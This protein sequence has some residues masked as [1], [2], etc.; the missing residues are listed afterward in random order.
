[1]NFNGLDSGLGEYTSPLHPGLSASLD[2]SIDHSLD[3]RLDPT[4]L[5]NMELDGDGVQLDGMSVSV[6]ESVHLVEGMYSELHTVVAEVGVPVTASHFDLQD[7]LLWVGNHAGHATSFFGPT[8]E[9]YSSFRVNATDDVR[10]IQSIESGVLFLNKNNLK[11]FTR[12]GLV[13]FD[14]VMDEID[15]MHSLLLTDNDSVLLGGLQNHIREIDLNAVQESEK[16]TVEVPGV[17]IMRQSNRFFFC[18]HTSGKVSLRDLRSFKLEHEFDAY[19]GSLSDFDVHGN[20]LVTCGFSN[21]MNGLS[22][23]RFLM[24][25][26]LRMMRAISPLQVHVDPLFLRFIPTYTSRLAI[27]S[28]SGQCQ[29]CEPTGLASPAD[30]F[31]I[32]TVGQLVMTFD[33]SSNKR[34]LVFGDSG[35]CVHLWADSPEATFNAYSRETE[36]PMPCMVD[37]L[38]HLDWNDDLLPLSLIPV[39]LITE[40]LLSDWPTANC[41]VIPRR[42][43][44]VDLEILR[45]MK[46]VGFIGYAPNPKTKLRNQ[47]PYKLKEMDVEFDNYNQIPESPIGREEDTYMYMVPKKYRKV[48]IKYSKLGLEDFD[49]KHYNKTLFAG[50]EPHIPNAYCNCMI[51]V[52][53]LLEPIRCHVQNHLCQK[54]FCLGCELGFLFHMLDLSRGDPCQASNFLR[55]FRTIPEASALGLI[56]ADSDEATGKMN[57][58]RL[59]QSWNRFILTQLHQ[60]TQEQEG[61]QAYRSVMGSTFGSSG[62]SVIGKLFGCEVENCSTCRCGKETVRVSS[63]LLF[64][65]QYP[66]V[67]TADKAVRQYEFAEVLKRSI[68]LEQ[69]TQAWCENCEKYQPTVQTRNIRC[70][71]DVL[72]INC[73]VNS[74]KEAEFW[75]CQAEYELRNKMRKEDLEAIKMKENN[76]TEWEALCNAEGLS[77]YTSIE[78]LKNIWIPNSIKMKLTKNKDLEVTNWTENEGLSPL[79]DEENT[80]LYDLVVSVAHVLD[81]RTGGS[82][83]AHIKVGETY[84]QR[85]EGV[86]H[87]QW[88]LFNDFLI[89]PIDKCE[90]VQFDLN[91]KIPCI[92]YYARRNLNSK[93]DLT[94]KNPIEA[95]VLLAEASL[96]RKQRKCHATFIPLMLNEMPQPNDLVGLD[97]EFVTLNQEEAEL[98]SDGTKSTIKPSQMSVARITC[99]RGQGPNEGVPFID[100]YISTQEQVVDYLTQYSGIKP[101]DLDAKISS[102]HLT[103]LKS[104]Y[105]KLRFLIDVGVKF[106]GHGLQK[107]FRVI[108]LLIPKEQVIDTVYLFHIPRKRMISLRFLAWYFLELKIQGETHDSIEDARTA[109]QLYR[110]YLELT[111][112]GTDVDEF[113]QI[114]K[115]LYEKGRKMDWR[116]PESEEIHSSPKSSQFSHL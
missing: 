27:I 22:C 12:G 13:M 66:D 99:V 107:D 57:L 95:S 90:A 3:P 72:V 77:F 114:L 39:P 81:P 55:A 116:V 28:Q 32:N 94:I 109:L 83:V 60:E 73:E 23:D 24:V 110:K 21:R 101:G 51:Q 62:E 91:W 34:A 100:D 85:K 88:Y 41:V 75:K 112:R 15:D 71:P 9:R 50:L 37:T 54:E 113:R 46:K 79:E 93:Y 104:T 18:G 74:A 8:M 45:T 49:F 30:I 108:N 10:Q 61:P 97:A 17:T 48:T 25:Y 40:S 58:G 31:H 87:K 106:V 6:P 84:H 14:Y 4:L 59:V 80:Y 44:P 26:D 92:L 1:M 7:E 111:K 103:T 20:L 29:F 52:L 56:L 68:C 96:A 105:L 65:L 76:P 42:A 89:E 63:S 67:N 16:Y 78:E 36:F 2:R 35:G 115:G 53:Y 19:S 102:K 43:P 38:P 11:C 82:L 69:N 70:L 86:T 33:V 5:Q 64:T 98:R 47:V